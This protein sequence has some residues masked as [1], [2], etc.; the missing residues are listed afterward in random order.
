MENQGFALIKVEGDQDARTEAWLRVFDAQNTKHHKR[1]ALSGRSNAVAWAIAKVG[2]QLNAAKLAS[3]VVSSGSGASLEHGQGNY[4]WLHMKQDSYNNKDYQRKALQFKFVAGF[5]DDTCVVIE[6]E[7]NAHMV[8]FWGQG[9]G[10]TFFAGIW[11][12]GENVKDR[13]LVERKEDWSFDVA[14]V[15]AGQNP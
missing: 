9:D 5:L 1:I 3:G 12:A 8:S 13:I 4:G 15:A 14:I 2:V 10:D 6:E 7:Q 11:G